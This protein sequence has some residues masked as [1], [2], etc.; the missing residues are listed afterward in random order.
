MITAPSKTKIL[1]VDDDAVEALGMC[2]MLS[3]VGLEVV[4]VA[5]RVKDALCLA[6]DTRP[7]V[8]ILDIRLAG[9][10]D[11]IEGALILRRTVGLPVIIVTGQSDAATMARAAE[12]QPV[13][14]LAKPVRA[15]QLVA[16]VETAISAQ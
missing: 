4:G 16:A 3:L 2:E 10:R 6:E 15:G 8:A 1:I 14:L 7:D 5:T 13:A 11:G 12:A 9:Q